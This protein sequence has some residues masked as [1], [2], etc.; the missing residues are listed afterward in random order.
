MVIRWLVASITLITCL[1]GLASWPSDRVPLRLQTRHQWLLRSFAER[2]WMLRVAF[3]FTATVT[4]GA[5]GLV[6]EEALPK[7]GDDASGTAGRVAF[8]TAST[9]ALGL[10]VVAR[11]RVQ[12]RFGTLF[13]VVGLG[14]AMNDYHGE[15]LKQSRRLYDRF[16]TVQ[17]DRSRGKDPVD[18]TAEAARELDALMNVDAPN[19]G[20][21]VAPVML[22]DLSMAVGSQS[23]LSH[24][25]GLI[26]LDDA[27]V[28]W[29]VDPRTRGR[30]GRPPTV[31]RVETAGHGPSVTAF[32]V[33]VMIHLTAENQPSLPSNWRLGDVVKVGFFDGDRGDRAKK[34]RVQFGPSLGREVVDPLTAVDTVVQEIT[35]AI[36][37]NPGQPVL[38]FARLPKTIAFA[39]G[40]AF[41]RR[42]LPLCG[43][44]G[45]CR[46]EGCRQPWKQLWPMRIRQSFPLPPEDWTEYDAV[47]VHREQSEVSVLDPYRNGT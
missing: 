25:T 10:T 43:L 6:I 44:K 21:D 22:W 36:H 28:P 19:T 1:A 31:R 27:P 46:N 41:T 16:Q 3:W 15:H 47:R 23:Q 26:E 33:A 17:V 4:T 5:W 38:V 29:L 39:V 13:Y 7:E 8:V 20:F 2:R 40:D 12:Q 37:C 14:A 18:A 42:E 45:T 32:A 35:N 34:V 30:S 11:D 9:V 24:V